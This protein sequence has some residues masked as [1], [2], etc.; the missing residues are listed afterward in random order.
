MQ[1]QAPADSF[2][3]EV[4]QGQRFQFGENWSVFL[5]VLD[6][7]RIEEA[8]AS[9]REMLDLQDLTGLRF[10]DIGSGSGLFSLAAVR[11]GAAHVYSFDY[12]PSSVGCAQELRQR[13]ASADAGW[14]IGQGSALDAEYLRSL[15]Q[16]DIVYSWGVLH[17]TGDM[18]TAL[19]NTV[20]AVADGGRLFISIY[21]DQGPRSHL[22]RMVKRLYNALP[23]PL[24]V[25]F[26]LLVMVPR[27]GLTAL[28]ATAL[29]RPQDYVRGWTNY[30]RSRGMSRWHDLVDWVGGYPFEVATP[31]QIFDFARTRGF[32]L[33]R[34][35]TCGG[36]L[37]CNQFVFRRSP[38]RLD[39]LSPEV[40]I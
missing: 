38:R 26:T 37:G 27:E 36:G 29:G 21:N 23:A 40:V 22:W 33:E 39:A 17:H 8:E 11:L 12:D 35:R 4:Q 30:K 24:R 31:E 15:G 32:T 10:L 19:E 3:E 25:P 6:D 7:E 18:W 9:L 34:L 5:K 14:T 1:T 13:Y 28:K 2:N 16:F 20:G